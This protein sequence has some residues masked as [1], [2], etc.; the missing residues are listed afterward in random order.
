VSRVPGPYTAGVRFRHRAAIGALA[1]LAVV[2]GQ[3]TPGT[4]PPSASRQ[5]QPRPTFHTEANYVRVDTY[6]TRDGEV[7]PDLTAADFEIL[8]D[9][10][11]QRIE[12]CEFVRVQTGGPRSQAREPGN[13]ASARRMAEEELRAVLD[14]LST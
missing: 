9:G 3:G 5:D 6:P 7:V 11:P 10:V 14:H 4:Q 13:V 2:P 1:I 8:E 12:Q